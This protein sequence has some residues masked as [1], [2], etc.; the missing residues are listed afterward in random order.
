[1]V[2]YLRLIRGRRATDQNLQRALSSCHPS[3]P[4]AR[5]GAGLAIE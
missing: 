4:P 5:P 2:P 1:M 3:Y